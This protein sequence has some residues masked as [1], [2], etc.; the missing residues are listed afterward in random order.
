MSLSHL[1]SNRLSNPEM[2]EIRPSNDRPIEEQSTTTAGENDHQHPPEEPPKHVDEEAGPP[3]PEQEKAAPH[4]VLSEKEKITT[5][6]IAAIVSFLSPV[7]ADIYYPALNLLSEELNVTR[8]TLNLTI[9][10]FMVGRTNLVSNPF[11]QT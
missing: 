3:E 11:Q 7:S 1:N 8:G 2:F 5:I 4:T 9:T 10:A 6:C